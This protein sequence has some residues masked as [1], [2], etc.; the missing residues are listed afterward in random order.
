MSLQRAP[1]V[2]GV[3]LTHPNVT[4]AALSQLPLQ[5]QSFPEHL[6]G[7]PPKAHG[8][9]GGIDTRHGQVITQ[10]IISAYYGEEVG[11][12]EGGDV[13]KGKS[14]SEWEKRVM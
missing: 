4:E 6:P 5:G 13:E 9:W 8:E 7:V 11:V 12:K 10:P 2:G 3:S 1:E 14:G